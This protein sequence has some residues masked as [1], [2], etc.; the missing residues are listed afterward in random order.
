M[1]RY[2]NLFMLLNSRSPFNKISSTSLVHHLEIGF[3]KVQ[4]TDIIAIHKHCN[5]SPCFASLW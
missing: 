5:D 1:L 3:N 4:P 2:L